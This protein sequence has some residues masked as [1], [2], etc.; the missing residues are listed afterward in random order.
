MNTDQPQTTLRRDQWI[1]AGWSFV[2]SA[3]TLWPFWEGLLRSG[4]SNYAFMLRDMMVPHNVVLNDLTRGSADNPPR[5]VPQDTFLGILSPTIPATFWCGFIVVAAGIVGGFFAA[6][7]IRDMAGGGLFP[8]AVAAFFVMW[9]PFTIERLLQGQWTVAAT[10]MLTPALAYT[11]AARRWGSWLFFFTTAAIV[12]TGTIIATVVSIAFA[13]R[14]RDKWLSA[15][16]GILMS[17]PWLLPSLFSL[18]RESSNLASAVSAEVFAARA[19]PGVGTLGALASLGGIWNADALPESLSLIA[20][21][22]GVTLALLLFTRVRELWKVYR[23]VTIMTVAA[24][25]LPA[26]LATPW[27]LDVMGW[28]ISHVP[29]FGIFRDTQKFVCLAI[30]GYIL[31]FGSLVSALREHSQ[32]SRTVLLPR[33]TGTCAPV[34]IAALAVLTVPAFPQDIAPARPQQ[35]SPAW[36]RMSDAMYASQLGRTLILPPGSYQQRGE[37]AAYNPAYKLLPGEPLDPAYLIVD[38]VLVDG[39]QEVMDLL[40]STMNG[41][42]RLA[43]RDISW[44]LVDSH[45]PGSQAPNTDVDKA[46]TAMQKAGYQQVVNMDGYQLFRVP[47]PARSAPDR[48]ESTSLSATAGM[49]IYWICLG[50]SLGLLSATVVRRLFRRIDA[51]RFSHAAPVAAQEKD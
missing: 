11:I 45:M 27:G 18:H 29:G 43:E 26:L 36:Q 21:F 6:R 33:L 22:S 16:V 35:L 19:E 4:Q 39:D 47:E 51:N 13:N 23:G 10:A 3:V 15:G 7:M 30:P 49:L 14:P 50:V 38:G 32:A 41:D 34:I 42:M 48:S 28:L 44:V 17:S 9:N 40:T 20:T 25:V 24:V 2:V 8:Q 46:V 12:P 5:N 31:L 37:F 1:I